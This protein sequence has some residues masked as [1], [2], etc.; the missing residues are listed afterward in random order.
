VTLCLFWENGYQGLN[1]PDADGNDVLTDDELA[2]PA[3]W[4]DRNGYGR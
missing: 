4:Q 1:A 3:L 2:G